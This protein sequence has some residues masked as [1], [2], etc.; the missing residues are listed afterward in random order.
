MR[1]FFAVTSLLFSAIVVA[2]PLD[3]LNS[4]ITV[5]SS[6]E[7]FNEGYCF[8]IFD[9]VHDVWPTT[10]MSQGKPLCAS[11]NKDLARSKVL[12]RLGSLRNE[13]SILLTLRTSDE[14]TTSANALAKRAIRVHNGSD[15]DSEVSG[16]ARNVISK[17]AEVPNW[18][19]SETSVHFLIMNS[20]IETH[21]CSE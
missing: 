3:N 1:L 21:R 8:G 14:D 20:Y 11:A 7:S 2:S 9:T 4:A 15:G 12:T 5:C 19:S 10:H 18:L 6:K 13:Y 16:L 17:T